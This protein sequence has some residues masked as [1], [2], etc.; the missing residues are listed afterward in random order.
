M[1]SEINLKKIDLPKNLIPRVVTILIAN[2][3]RLVERGEDRCQWEWGP[4]ELLLEKK[5]NSWEAFVRHQGTLFYCVADGS[6]YNT[7]ILEL[8]I[9]KSCN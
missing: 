9:R 7:D 3:G 6:G 2:R 8:L 4:F 5:G 1:K